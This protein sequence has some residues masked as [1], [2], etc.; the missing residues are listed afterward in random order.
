MSWNLALMARPANAP[1][2]WEMHDTEAFVRK[3]VLERSPSVVLFQELPGLVPYIETH[4]M[5]GANPRTHSGNLATL[6]G[7]ELMDM[8]PSWETVGSFCLMV[9]LGGLTIANVHLASGPG[10][11]SERLDQL[12]Q[13][14]SASPMDALIVVG[15]TNTRVAEEASIAELGLDGLRPPAPTWNSK[16]NRFR[17]GSAEFAAYFSRWFTSTDVQVDAPWVEDAAALQA[18]SERFFV[19]DHFAFGATARLRPPLR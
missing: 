15:D 13:I 17:S 8:T 6:V 4:A 3:S 7:H 10:A 2:L 18:G 12:S 5:V 11:A 19:S 1:Q 9:Q 16:K 14:R